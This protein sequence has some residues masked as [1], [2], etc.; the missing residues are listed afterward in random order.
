MANIEHEA[1]LKKGSEAWHRW[2]EDNP[3]VK[4][5]LRGIDLHGKC[6][7]GMQFG[8]AN[9]S[10]ADLSRADMTGA[11]LFNANLVG[12]N[13]ENANLSHTI[14]VGANLFRANLEG[15]DISAADMRNALALTQEQIRSCAT[16]RSARLP[17]VYLHDKVV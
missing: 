1:I 10:G 14:L 4:P 3:T 15:A 13:L 16:A 8:S 11:D 6:L 9:L 12:A 17:E 7:I 2:R 5:D